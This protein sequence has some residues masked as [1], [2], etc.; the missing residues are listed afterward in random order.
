LSKRVA[1]T[2]RVVATPGSKNCGPKLL[3][4]VATE[5]PAAGGVSSKLS[6]S[7]PQTVSVPNSGPAPVQLPVF[8]LLKV[9][10]PATAPGAI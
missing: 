10:L 5:R 4:V 9:T 7:T 8:G 6:I 1:L 2:V 3:K